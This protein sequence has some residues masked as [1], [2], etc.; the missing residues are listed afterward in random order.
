MIRRSPVALLSLS[1]ALLFVASPAL[2]GPPP[3]TT[4]ELI[5]GNLAPAANGLAL[6]NAVLAAGPNTLIKLEPG[7]YDLAGQQIVLPNLVN[8]EGSGRDITRIFSDLTFSPSPSVIEVPAG[9]NAEIRELTVQAS[10][11]ISATAITVRSDDLLLFEVNLEVKTERNATGVRIIGASPRLDEV[12]SRTLAAG[13]DGIGFRVENGAGAVFT[14]CLVF[15]SN[16]ERTFTG[17]FV[18]ESSPVIE[19]TILFSL[20]NRSNTGIL[21]T[22][23][24]SQAT[25]R[26]TRAIIQGNESVG[27]DLQ[28]ESNSRV[29]ESSFFVRSN[30]FA[31]G[32]FLREAT[33]KITETTFDVA[34]LFFPHLS[35]FGA[36]LQGA[37]SLDSNQSNY[38][39]TVFAVSNVG[40]G[41][42]R[43][44]ASQLIG[45][46]S[47]ALPGPLVCAQS[48]NGAYAA[49]NNFCN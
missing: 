5:A 3:F 30:D 17:I 31:A 2:A 46:A 13:G 10:S 45:N 37:S 28:R 29:K 15:G 32:V 24:N 40:S 11:G 38:E 27:L 35:V 47:P 12:F 22:G 39:S 14:S 44:G 8:I 34:E 1:L 21:V 36:R 18:E 43:F 25:I 42:A 9:V 41:Q 26:N 4:T 48:Y 6:R 19:G 7:L 16:V 20:F 33:A 23:A 49:I